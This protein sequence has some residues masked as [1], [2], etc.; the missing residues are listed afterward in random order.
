MKYVPDLKIFDVVLIFIYI[1]WC[2]CLIM[3]FKNGYFEFQSI[4][5][6]IQL[7]GFGS[8]FLIY[9]MYDKK[10]RNNKI[11]FTWLVICIIQFLIYVLYADLPEFSHPKGSSLSPIRGLLISV[12][13]YR[14]IRYL[15]YKIFKRELIITGR[16]DFVGRRSFEEH[17]TVGKADFIFSILGA[18]IILFAMIFL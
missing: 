7:T 10:L 17:R 8:A 6:A 13:T 16:G 4:K 18:M 11:F 3:V 15:Y 9:G 14:V 1:I 12:L 5:Q 2:L